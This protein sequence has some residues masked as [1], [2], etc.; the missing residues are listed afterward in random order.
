MRQDSFSPFLALAIFIL[1]FLLVKN[2]FNIIVV[3]DK[4]SWSDVVSK[5]STDDLIAMVFWE[6]DNAKALCNEI[7]EEKRNGLRDQGIENCSQK[8]LIVYFISMLVQIDNFLNQNNHNYSNAYFG[9]F[10]PDERLIVKE[11]Q[12]LNSAFTKP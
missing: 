10:A 12:F 3:D 5:V 1:A 11:S 2:Y 9:P 7:V 6:K 4:Q 8:I